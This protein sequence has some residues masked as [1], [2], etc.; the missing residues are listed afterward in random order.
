MKKRLYVPT[1]PQKLIID[2]ELAH[3]R[4]GI[5]AGMGLGKT[6]STLCVLDS[7]FDYGIETK[8]AL[9]IAPKRVAQS[10]WPGELKKWS[11]F[12]ALDVSVLLG[13]PAQRV[14]ALKRDVPLFTIN[15]ENI[16]WL[17]EW[18]KTNEWEWP[19]GTV[20]ADE[21]TRLKST[22]V[23]QLISKKG[24]AFLRSSG[25]SVRGGALAEIAHAHVHRWINLTGTPAP[26]GLKDLWGQTWFLDKGE[27]LGRSF[28]AFEQRWFMHVV[29]NNNY[30]KLAPMP[31]A[32]REI[33]ARLR[34]ICL[35][36]DPRKFFDLEKPIT[37][38]IY[39]ELPDSARQLYKKLS[40]EFY[41]ELEGTP[42]V[43]T[44]AASK[45]MKCLQLASGAIYTESADGK[46]LQWKEIHDVKLQALQSVIEEAAGMPV[47]VSYFFK[48]DKARLA[49][50]FP[51]ARLLDDDPQTIEDWN[52]GK[53]PVLLC[54]PESAGHGLNLQ[55]GGNILVFFSHW[56]S[57]ES[58]VQTVERIGPMRQKQS[59]YNRPVYVYFI[60][61]RGTED[62]NVMLRR[63]TKQKVEDVLMEAL[64]W[65]DKTE[66]RSQYIEQMIENIEIG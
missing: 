64:H 19:F 21:S 41:A 52:D 58:F 39:V 49:K 45:S 12:S 56:W 26:N 60:V 30:Q 50:A 18:L 16:P 62:E 25:G 28:S 55:D 20:I 10:T 5:F 38:T 24:N 40:K 4:C 36:L 29:G 9:I 43:A 2:F 37:R 63:A 46:T 51:K 27:R 48:S 31:H 47:L 3:Q 23:V 61:A 8:P 42:I 15:Y 53:I 11:N 34:D 35:A 14:Q 1:D 57:L 6:S 44:N 54:H 17:L 13:S 66:Q 32:D 22:R 7:L 65:R 59:G 33:H